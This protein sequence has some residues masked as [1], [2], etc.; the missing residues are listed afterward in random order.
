M[1]FMAA[2]ESFWGE[3][4]FETIPQDGSMGLVY[5]PTFVCKCMVNVCKYSSPMEHHRPPKPFES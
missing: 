2:C 4:P 5:L 1:G 3:V